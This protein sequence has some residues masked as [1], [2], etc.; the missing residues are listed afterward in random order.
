MSGSSRSERALI[1]LEQILETLNEHRELMG[2]LRNRL[3]QVETS[4]TTLMNR[5]EPLVSSTTTSH[6]L[7]IIYPPT[8]DDGT[9]VPL[10]KNIIVRT[11]VLLLESIMNYLSTP[12]TT[13][14]TITTK[15]DRHTNKVSRIKI[16]KRRRCCM[17]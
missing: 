11:L 9:L 7:S 1:M 16:G 3:E 13:T 8:K 4:L 5:T 14:T 17:E 6:N 10:R 2:D 12:T 15:S